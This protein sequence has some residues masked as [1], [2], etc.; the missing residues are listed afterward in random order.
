MDE[1]VDES[2]GFRYSLRQGKEEKKKSSIMSMERNN[3]DF[4]TDASLD[5]KK[6]F[7]Q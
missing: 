3:F 5:H 6:T 7:V 4:L 1:E 2:L